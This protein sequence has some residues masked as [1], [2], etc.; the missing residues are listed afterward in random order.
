MIATAIMPVLAGSPRFEED[1]DGA[2]AGRAAGGDRTAF[3]ALLARYQR[4]VYLIALSVLRDSDLAMDASQETFIRL[5]AHLK[6]FRGEAPLRTWL[7]RI[8]LHVAVDQRRRTKRRGEQSV[9]DAALASFEDPGALPDDRLARAELRQ[10]LLRSFEAL[11]EAQRTVLALRDVEG[12]SYGEIAKVLRIP[13]G[14][15]M[16]RLFYARRALRERF[17][18]RESDDPPLRKA[19]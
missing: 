18:E 4:T 19:S 16:S 9:D 6:S 3:G 12:L 17:L 14:T 15:V 8:A 1:L 10:G 2:L 5:H 7:S 11:S 13:V